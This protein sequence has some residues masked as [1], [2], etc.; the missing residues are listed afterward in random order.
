MIIYIAVKIDF[1]TFAQNLHKTTKITFLLKLCKSFQPRYSFITKIHNKNEDEG[2]NSV[3]HDI[4]YISVRYVE[5]K[6]YAFRNKNTRRHLYNALQDL[7]I[8]V[9]FEKIEMF[10][11]YFPF[12]V[13]TMPS[14]YIPPNKK[15][16]L[17]TFVRCWYLVFIAWNM[18]LFYPPSP[19]GRRGETVCLCTYLHTFTNSNDLWG[20]K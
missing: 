4:M 9:I 6:Y 8:F 12:W 3:K 1:A 14:D 10:S 18:Y 5:M 20:K 16:N 15:Y 2:I 13:Y 19:R 17:Y 7:K 11:F